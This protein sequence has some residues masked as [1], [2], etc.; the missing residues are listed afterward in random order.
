MQTTIDRK[1]IIIFVAIAYGISIA[2]G[3]AIYFN[4]GLFSKYPWEMWPS[5]ILM[6]QALMFAPLVANIATRLIT[7]EGWSNTL[8]RPHVRRSWRLYLAAWFLPILASFVGGAIYFLL[9]PSRFDA[10]AQWASDAGLLGIWK[11]ADPVTLF[12]AGVGMALV[13]SATLGL[14]LSFGE[15]FGWRA[16]LLP[17]L[18]PL[19]GRRAVLLVGVIHGAWHWPVILLGYEYGFG[20]WGEPVVGPLLFVVFVLFLSA[21]LAWLTLRSGSVWPAALGH[22]AINASAVQMFPYLIGDADRLVGP[23]PVG[24]IGS[25]GY[26]I[27]ALLIFFSARALAP[28]AGPRPSSPSTGYAPRVATAGGVSH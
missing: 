22:A 5:A 10:S 9:F 7:R 23:L 26:A 20:Y 6:L 15:E 4:G 2:L 1:R 8:L 11:D 16:Y 27:L 14:L 24:I 25:L 12:L 3:L 18:M 28:M 19:G 21:F 13:G 17:K